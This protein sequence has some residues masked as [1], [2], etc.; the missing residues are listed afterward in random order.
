MAI[1]ITMTGAVNGQ[2]Y[3][4]R[5]MAVNE[6]GQP[7]T[8]LEGAVV[9]ARPVADKLAS[10][11]P[12]GTVLKYPG[13]PDLILTN[14]ALDTLLGA[15]GIQVMAKQSVGTQAYSTSSR[16][17]VN[18]VLWQNNPNIRSYANGS[19]YN[20]L[21]AAFRD[22]ILDTKSY[23]RTFG[24]GPGSTTYQINTTDKVYLLR[25]DD[26]ATGRYL[27]TLSN[28]AADTSYWIM[29]YY[30]YSTENNDYYGPRYIMATG[31]ISY[32]DQPASKLG[33]RPVFTLPKTTRVNATPNADGSYNLIL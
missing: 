31:S 23:F 18:Y 11:L 1:E 19:Y 26:Y 9:S 25:P 16:P 32:S 24:N 10:S 21:P 6:R 30:T 8:S 15:T 4:I 7:Q 2:E 33:F 20:A 13:V 27:G 3:F 14:R 29:D 22:K 17:T 5:T 28:R 12:E